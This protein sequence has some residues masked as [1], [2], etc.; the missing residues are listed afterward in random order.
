MNKNTWI[1]L[2]FCLARVLIKSI[3]GWDWAW[4]I[5]YYKFH[6]YSGKR[7]K[8]KICKYCTAKPHNNLLQTL[9]ANITKENY[10]D[11]PSLAMR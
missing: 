10:L 1:K 3:N 9:H 2:Q 5:T 8:K 7:Q 11:D 4:L 6:Y